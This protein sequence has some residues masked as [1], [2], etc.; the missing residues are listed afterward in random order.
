MLLL[1]SVS[2]DDGGRL[3]RVG[4]GRTD[5]GAPIVGRIQ[6]R[7]LAVAIGREASWG[8]LW[9]VVRHSMACRLTVTPILDGVVL[10]DLAVTHELA[11]PPA[12]MPVDVPLK[13]Y[14]SRPDHPDEP[15]SRQALRGVWFAPRVEI[16]ALEDGE[17]LAV[18]GFE[19]DVR[20]LG[21]SR[22]AVNTGA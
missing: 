2:D 13:V 22:G 21:W 8:P 11:A 3:L 4:T 5:D 1:W 20:P 16:E 17:V 14:L 10:D 12:A 9:L 7:P 19:I 18:G 6:P 15:W